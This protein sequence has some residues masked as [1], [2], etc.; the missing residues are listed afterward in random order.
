VNAPPNRHALGTAM[1][2]VLPPEPEWDDLALRRPGQAAREQALVELEAMRERGKVRAWVNRA[3]DVK[4]DERAWRVGANGEETVGD[5]LDKLEGRGWHVLHAVP[6]GDRGSDIDHVLI[7]PGGVYTVNT[8][9]HP[10]NKIWVGRHAIKVNGHSVPYL[11]N[12][13]FEAGRTAEMLA[14]ALG[15]AVPVRPVL[16]LLTGTLVPNVSVAQQP[17]DVIVL[18]RSDVPGVFKRAPQR[19]SAEQVAQVYEVARRSTTW[20]R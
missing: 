20:R 9:N 4:T 1:A 16:V 3:L 13:R 7:G 14:R 15:W 6:V 12:S 18:D 2:L 5:R 11:R 8:K 17:D 19:I 10:D